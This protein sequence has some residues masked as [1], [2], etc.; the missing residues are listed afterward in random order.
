MPKQVLHTIT[1]ILRRVSS[2]AHSYPLTLHATFSII[3]WPASFRY[4]LIN[5]K[6]YVKVKVKWSRYRPVVAQRVGGGITLLFHDRSTRRGWVVSST[7]RQ[8]LTSGKDP[9]PIL[10]ETGWAPGPVW[11]GGKSRPHRDSIP[12]RPARSYTDWATRPTLRSTYTT[13]FTW[14]QVIRNTTCYRGHIS[15]AHLEHIRHKISWQ[16]FYWPRHKIISKLVVRKWYCI[17][18]TF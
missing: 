16:Q 12:D 9:V 7:P 14:K 1:T 3:H 4:I 11:T 10:Q 6:E 13:K 5:I 17:W 15:S 8:H 2:S 18:I